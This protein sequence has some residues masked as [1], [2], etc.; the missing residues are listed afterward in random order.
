[1]SLDLDTRLVSLGD[2]RSA[3]AWME[4]EVGYRL[5]GGSVLGL[6]RPYV[7]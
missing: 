6:V 4:A 5:W 3:G 7:A 2:G 1:M